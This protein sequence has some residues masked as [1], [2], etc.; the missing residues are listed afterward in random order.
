MSPAACWLTTERLGLRRFTIEDADWLARLYNDPDVTRYLGGTKDRTQIEEMLDR[1]ILQ[2][3]S[4][5]PGLGIW[6]TVDRQTG[7]RLGFHLLNHIQGESIIQVGFSL[8]KAEWGRGLGTEMASALLRYGFH[9]LRLP[10]IV[11]M[12]S[13]ANHASQRVLLKIG[14]HRRGERAFAHP[15]YAAEGPM[16]WFEREAADWIAEHGIE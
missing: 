6:M 2:Y 14:L 5:Y 10:R 16:A 4:D 11:G 8:V 1:R 9:D 12:A 3:Y 13:L 15:A 7:R